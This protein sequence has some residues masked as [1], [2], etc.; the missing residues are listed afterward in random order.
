MNMNVFS[1]HSYVQLLFIVF[2]SD[3]DRTLFNAK[4]FPVMACKDSI[5]MKEALWLL[6][7]EKD[8]EMLERWRSSWRLSLEEIMT[9][10]DLSTEFQWRRFVGHEC[11]NAENYW[12][13]L[14]NKIAW[15]KRQVGCLV[16]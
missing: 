15:L 6:N 13:T 16:I 5:G 7:G 3:Y 10:S 2:Q 4:L 1:L 12:V 9:N 8:A 11:R 14:D